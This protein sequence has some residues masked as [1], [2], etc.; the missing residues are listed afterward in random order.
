MKPDFSKIKLKFKREPKPEKPP[1]EP[2][3]VTVFLNKYS[4]LIHIPLSMIMC[5]VLEWLSQHSFVEALH[6]V[7]G[8][9][10]AYLYNSF[11]IFSVYNL[12]YLTKR[13]TFMRMVVSAVFVMLG[14]VNCVVLF[15]RVTPFGFTDLSMIT[16]LL[17][18]QNTNYFTAQQAAMSLAAIGVYVALMV[19]LFIKGAQNESKLPFWLRLILVVGCFVSIP[20]M[21]PKLQDI[22]I[23]TG[24]FGNLAQGYKNYGYLY[25]FTTSFM[26]RGMSKPINYS[27][28]TVDKVLKDTD[29]GESTIADEDMPNVVIVL[30][31]S[32]YDVSEAD[33][34]Q[35]SEDPIPYFHELEAN[36]STG[37]CTVPVVG[38]G[39][40]NSEFEVLTGMSCIFFGPGEY[41]QKTILKT[42]PDCES[43]ANLLGS[44][45]MGT[46]VVH[47]NGGNFY[48]R[49][50]AF[51]KMGFDTFTCKE[52]LDITDYTP[53]GSWPLDDILIPA[54]LDAMNSTE[55]RDLVYTITVGTHGDYPTEKIIEDPAVTVKAVGKSEAQENQ[56]EYYI[57]M[58]RN[59]DNWMRDYTAALDATGEPTLLIMFGDHL[60]TMGLTEDEIATHD[61]Y[62][63]KYVTWNNFGMS[64]EDADLTTYQLTSEYLNRLGVHGGTIINYNQALTSRGAKPGSNK[65]MKNLE[66]LQYDL[67]YGKRYAYGDKAEESNASEIE[68]G[69]NDV[70]V[71]ACYLFGDKLHIYG[72]NF[73]KWSKV[74][75]NGEKVST[76]YESGQ[77]L[78]IPSSAIKSGDK[79]VVNQ[80]GSSSTIFRSSNE[81]TFIDPNAD[82]EETEEEEAADAEAETSS[83]EE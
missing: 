48:S 31:E 9:T 70:T 58:L 83:E 37:H 43:V 49:A 13:K 42:A 64:K 61:L 7:T 11:L 62:Q 34:L 30:L 6:F 23:L 26:D 69:I 53:K 15:N 36:Y 73:S 47:N 2:S 14:I 25:G 82:V 16:D 52:M 76:T 44:M 72:Q 55:S 32:F 4:L 65:Y 56:W 40:C 24:Y 51:S 27:K 54:T 12:V 10:G 18:M 80:V 81:I 77:V 75:V 38:A 68:M 1:K 20:V 5:F 46:H 28:K 17:T 8:H 35:T 79:L 74:Y 22:G 66:L 41:P 19:R 45:G 50:N 21:T 59:M 71:D 39:T 57:N 60:P 78:T 63:T 67:L 33:F 3:K 29:M